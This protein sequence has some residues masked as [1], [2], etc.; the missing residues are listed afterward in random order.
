MEKEL[1]GDGN[2][3]GLEAMQQS[4]PIKGGALPKNLLYRASIEESRNGHIKEDWNEIIWSL[5]LK[6][7]YN[8]QELTSWAHLKNLLTHEMGEKGLFGMCYSEERTKEFEWEGSLGIVKEDT[9]VLEGIIASEA[10][11]DYYC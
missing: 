8:L 1:E 9:L 4:S 7:I 3:N 6:A 10:K 2:F 5:V 11:G